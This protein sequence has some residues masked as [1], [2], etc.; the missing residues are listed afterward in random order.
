MQN[1]M[2]SME[3]IILS[4]ETVVPAGAV[5]SA[6]RAVEARYSAYL[7]EAQR[8]IQA[9]IEEIRE[10]GGVDPRVADIVR[11]AGLSNK[12]FYRHF[13][14]KD[15]LLL[16]VLEEGMQRQHADFE[17]YLADAKSPVERVRKWALCVVSLAVDPEQSAGLR[18]L[19]VYQATLAEHL[20]TQM[21]S[22]V[23]QLKE[24]LEQALMEAKASGEV[25]AEVDP[26]STA[27]HFYFS[28]FGWVH[29][30]VL[31]SVTP[32]QAEADGVVDFAM[33]ALR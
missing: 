33:R 31:N 2:L 27:D 12:A 14:S 19:L 13:K 18:P 4:D 23:D 30:R 24:P 22:Y 28:V 26:K 17:L 25:G 20:N 5:R 7:D 3:N 6:E 21:W 15:E 11:R 16:A 32:T 9:G 10:K 8:L 29:G 1:M